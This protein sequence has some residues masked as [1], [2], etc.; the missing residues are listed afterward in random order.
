[1]LL[2]LKEENH[3]SENHKND[4]PGNDVGDGGGL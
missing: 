2:N 1:M 4:R 3:E